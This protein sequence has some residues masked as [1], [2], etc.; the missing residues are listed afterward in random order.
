[1]KI[2]SLLFCLCLFVSCG[3]SGSGWTDE[4]DQ[5]DDGVDLTSLPE[6][7]PEFTSSPF[8]F[9]TDMETDLESLGIFNLSNDCDNVHYGWDFAPNWGSYPDN[10][11]PVLAV[12]DGII[13]QVVAQGTNTYED[14][15]HNTFGVWLAV[16]QE[17]TV[18]YNF[19]P[20]L[21]FDETYALQWLVVNEGDAV[22]AGDL[23]G[24]LP[25]VEGNMGDWLIHIDFKISTGSDTDNFVCPLNYF[26][27][28]WK[29]ENEQTM[30]DKIFSSCSDLCYD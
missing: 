6:T 21:T 2:F 9:P 25:K 18:Y 14:Q 12:A 19:E 13:S 20:F 29:N 7:P 22:N 5:G 27:D 3:S 10:L 30:I 8:T 23:L 4:G 17:D 28:D 26:S 24:Y 16:S 15:T 11:V 1:M